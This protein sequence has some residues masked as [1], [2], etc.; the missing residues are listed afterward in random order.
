MLDLSL[1]QQ[2]KYDDAMSKSLSSLFSGKDPKIVANHLAGEFDA[3]TE[4]V[5]LAKQKEIYAGWAK[6]PGAYP[7]K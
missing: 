4:K 7:T 5:G 6:K 3:I 1:L 2:D